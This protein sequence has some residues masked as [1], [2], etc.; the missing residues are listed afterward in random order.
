MSDKK[1]LCRCHFW[2][3]FDYFENDRVCPDK[4]KPLS[5]LPRRFHPGPLQPDSASGKALQKLLRRAPEDAVGLHYKWLPIISY[6]PICPWHTL[7][8]LCFLSFSIFDDSIWPKASWAVGFFVGLSFAET[9]YRNCCQFQLSSDCRGFKATRFKDLNSLECEHGPGV[10]GISGESSPLTTCLC[11]LQST[12]VLLP[13][14]AFAAPEWLVFFAI[15]T[16]FACPTRLCE[17]LLLL[18]SF[19]Y[20]ASRE[21]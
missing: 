2:R 13:C 10:G 15:Q 9:L 18:N 5:L 16:A 3:N 11:S 14:C 21:S 7:L 17:L 19:V 20:F 8:V 4:A 1:R 12:E 6:L